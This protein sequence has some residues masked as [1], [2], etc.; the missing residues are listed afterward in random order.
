MNHKFSKEVILHFRCGECD[1]WWSYATTEGYV[2]KDFTCPHCE[3]KAP[4]DQ[5]R[6]DSADL[7]I[8]R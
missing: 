2:P 1:N 7:S 3:H 5:I 8:A 6:Y 4:C